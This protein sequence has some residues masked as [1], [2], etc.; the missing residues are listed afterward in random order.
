MYNLVNLRD[1]IHAILYSDENSKVRDKIRKASAKFSSIYYEK[2]AQQFKSIHPVD[3]N[4]RDTTHTVMLM[5]I[6]ATDWAEC[7]KAI[8]YLCDENIN[9]MVGHVNHLDTEVRDQ[10]IRV[11]QEVGLLKTKK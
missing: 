9:G 1:D 10:I 7:M 4:D 5:G 8:D 11:F 3:H 6:N 2:I